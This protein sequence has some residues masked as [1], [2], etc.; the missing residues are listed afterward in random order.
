[1]EIQSNKNAQPLNKKQGILFLVTLTLMSMAG[2]VGSDV[3]LPMLPEIG[4]SLS[5][6]TET[7]QL[8]LGI[9]LLGLSVSQLFLGP[10]TDRFGRKTLLLVCMG[11]YL[12]AS[13]GCAFSSSLEQFLAFRLLQ[14][15]GASAGLVIG[16]AIIGDLFEPKEASK[17]FATIFPL[18]GMSPAISPAIGGF[19]GHYF[20]WQAT[21]IFIGLFA[22]SVFVLVTMTIPESLAKKDRKPLHLFKILS[23]YPVILASRKFLYYAV[24]PCSAYIAF[25]SYIAQS[26]FIFHAHGFGERAIGLF[27]ITLSLTY[28]AGGYFSKRYLKERTMDETIDIGF[29]YFLLGASLFLLC[30]FFDLPLIFMVLFI[31][32]LTFGNGFLIP[33]G[34]A[35]V[36]SSFAGR[37][38]YASGLLGFLQLGGA[39]LTTSFIGDISLNQVGRLAEFIFA[40]VIIGSGVRWLLAP[41]K[42][43][44]VVN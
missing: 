43:I 30:A 10:L 18:V 33:L 7:M 5:Q 41:K 20:G 2:L 37:I 26:P 34:T 17:V 29:K 44:E 15:I 39:A 28:V 40:V 19:I 12:I 16:R 25:F 22:L 27:Y 36:V 38:G 35:G 3:Y 1:M 13:L 42:V 6:S 11:G 21:F 4:K 23:T 8:T 9:Y 32:V 31:S 14:A 24:A